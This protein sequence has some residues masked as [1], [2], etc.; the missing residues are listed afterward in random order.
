[1]QARVVRNIDGLRA[2]EAAWTEMVNDS[3]FQAPFHAWTW[4]DAW[5]RCFGGGAELFVIVGEDPQGR[6]QF[7]APLMRERHSLRGLPVSEI[8]FLANSISPQGGILVRNGC[9]GPEALD[10][11]LKCLAEH[12]SEW[13]LATLRNIPEDVPYLNEFDDACVLHGFRT[14]REPGWNSAYVALD[15]TFDDYLAAQLGKNRRRGIVQKVRQLSG[16]PGYRVA[17]FRRPDEVSAALAHAFAVS[18]A[19]WKGPLATDMSGEPSRRLFYEDITQRLAQRGQI[20]IWVSFL[21]QKPLAIQYDIV[22]ASVMYLVVND[23]DSDYQRQS[24]GTV[25]LYHVLDRLY[26]EKPVSRF[27]FSGDVYEY[28]SQWATGMQSH[29]T[30]ELFHDGLYSRFLWWTKKRA[31]P[32]LRNLRASVWPVAD[33]AA[34][35]QPA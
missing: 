21:V 10:A 3:P 24:P 28:K 16:Q 33:K 35:A 25:L 19:S 7:V 9:T 32:T 11:M 17:E 29:A 27:Q 13:D 23:F 22:S 31:L 5:W 14:L 8:R 2:L 20:R 1:M 18:R 6:L 26:E 15:G 12:R 4:Y 34:P 30:L